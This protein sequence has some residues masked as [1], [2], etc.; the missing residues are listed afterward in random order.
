MRTICDA[1]EPERLIGVRDTALLN[2][3]ASSG[4]RVSEVAGLKRQQIRAKGG[5]VCNLGARQK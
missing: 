5:R 1:P 4:L 2:T 3:L